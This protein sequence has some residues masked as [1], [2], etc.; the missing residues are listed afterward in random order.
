MGVV[1]KRRGITT[2]PSEG[3]YQE[4]LKE[5]FFL[6]CG[7]TSRHQVTALVVT[8]L[9]LAPLYRNLAPWFLILQ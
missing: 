3:G 6:K 2:S 9:Y 1:R 8:Q 7:G 5:L 4:N